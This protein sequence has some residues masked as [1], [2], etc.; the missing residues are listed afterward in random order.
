MK[1]GAVAGRRMQCSAVWEE[2][3]YEGAKRNMV[4]WGWELF[5]EI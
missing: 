5:R 3:H 2:F 4:G 1:A